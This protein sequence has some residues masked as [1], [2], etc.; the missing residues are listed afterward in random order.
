MMYKEAAVVYSQAKLTESP[1][2]LRDQGKIMEY[3][4]QESPFQR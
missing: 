2:T 1:L 4:I 3:L